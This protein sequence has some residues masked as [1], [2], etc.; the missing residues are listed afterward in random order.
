MWF[1]IAA[2]IA[3][4][5]FLLF[6]GRNRWQRLTLSPLATIGLAIAALGIMI[7]FWTPFLRIPVI[8][9]GMLL[10]VR[11]LNQG[12]RGPQRDSDAKDLQGVNL[13]CPECGMG[14]SAGSAQCIH[15]AAALRPHDNG[16]V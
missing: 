4:L 3:A 5:A 10:F 6:R 11:G 12:R 13:W 14:N 9:I 7:G 8:G 2:L 15:C 1:G 16:T